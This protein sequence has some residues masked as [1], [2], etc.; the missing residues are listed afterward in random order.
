MTNPKK[1]YS[2]DEIGF[3]AA[4]WRTMTDVEMGEALGRRPAAVQAMRGRI[5]LTR[6]QGIAQGAPSGR[7]ETP[8]RPGGFTS[9]QVE[10]ALGNLGDAEARMIAAIL[11]DPAARGLRGPKTVP[12]PRVSAGGEHAGGLKLFG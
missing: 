12:M 6:V 8:A 11:A 1:P 9:A 3:V 5:R 10:W 7:I 4:N 2:Q